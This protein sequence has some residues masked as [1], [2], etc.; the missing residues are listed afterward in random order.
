MALVV[1]PRREPLAPSA[2]LGVGAAARALLR[3]LS[4]LSEER[5]LRLR[6]ARSDD[7]LVVCGDAAEL[8]WADG[9]VYLGRDAEAPSLLVPTA[10]NVEQ[11]LSLLERALVKRLKGESA[12]GPAP[13]AVCFSPWLVVSAGSARPVVRARLPASFELTSKGDS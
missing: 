11:P 12:A 2:V 5:L 6:A 7:A 13:W 9:V 4:E 8:P 3:R 1:V 10:L